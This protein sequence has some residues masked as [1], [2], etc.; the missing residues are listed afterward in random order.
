MARSHRCAPQQATHPLQFHLDAL[1]NEAKNLSRF[2]DQETMERFFI[3]FRKTSG[4]GAFPSVHRISERRR[5][6]LMRWPWEPR[7]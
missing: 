1:V 6:R 2:Q 4:E 5:V 3:P 7:P